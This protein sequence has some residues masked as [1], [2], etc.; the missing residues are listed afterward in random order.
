[1][2]QAGKHLAHRASAE[3]E[4]MRSQTALIKRPRYCSRFTSI[5]LWF[6]FLMGGLWI[7][8]FV[9]TTPPK[10]VSVSLA[11]PVSLPASGTGAGDLTRQSVTPADVCINPFDTSCWMNNA[12]N[13]AAQEIMDALKPLITAI[14][15]SP[16]NIITQTPPADTYQNATLDTWWQI[17][18]GVADTAL[19][20]LI[21][22][23]GYNVMVG[24]YLGLTHSEI[25]AFLPRA[26]LALGAAHFSLYFLGLF[27]DLENALCQ[28]ALMLAA[29]SI[30]TTYIL[31]LF[32]GN[33]AG[34]GLLLWILAV[35]LGIMCFL[36][37]AQMGIRLALLW[38]LI[39][40]AGPGLACLTLPQTLSYGRMWLSLTAT[41]VMVQFFQVVT[42]ALG[43][44]LI[45]TL[46]ATNIFN[47]DQ[48]VALLLICVALVYLVL[49]IPGMVH[50]YALRPMMDAS[51]GVS[52]AYQGA[53]YTAVRVAA[54]L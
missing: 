28:V 27:I 6:V 24:R 33:L 16:A 31:T 23:G 44:V 15:S 21:V 26:I 51:S 11:R 47:L 48:T 36:L 29:K 4:T 42:L 22:I 10:P 20:C 53:M 8:G 41:T 18:V 34:E 19:A 13:W 7:G 54:L 1:M 40:L 2:L 30:L 43:G 35:V 52:S 37:G 45:A 5:T 39:A 49:R 25:A 12:A 38:V 3:K 17:F 14:L 32:Q 9:L 46:G 50:R